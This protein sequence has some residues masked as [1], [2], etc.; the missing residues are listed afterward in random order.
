MADV[1]EMSAVDLAECLGVSERRVRQLADEGVVIKTQRGRY[2]AK[3]SVRNYI[4]FLRQQERA[5]EENIE[6]IKVAREAEGLM[7]DQLRKRKTEL[8]VRKMEN[9]LHSSEDVAYFWNTMVL[10]T[11][12]RITSIPVKVAPLLVGIEDRKEVQSILKREIA[13]ALN[14]IADYDVNKFD[15]EFED[16][17]YA[18][19]DS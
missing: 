12:S 1:I 16:E 3:Q 15:E 11:K 9:Q 17:A 5:K 10:A 8:Q 6:K 18:R 4:E 19:E 14:E 2:D 7:H 13:D